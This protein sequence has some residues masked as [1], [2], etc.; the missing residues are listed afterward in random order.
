MQYGICQL[1]I[2]PL[3]LL[4]DEA[5]EMTSQLLYGDHFKVLEQRKFWSKIR[6][7]FDNYEGWVSN[8]QI[9]LITEE[10]YKSIEEEG[11]KDIKLTSDLVSFASTDNNSLIPLVIGSLGLLFPLFLF[12]FSSFYYFVCYFFIFYEGSGSINIG[13]GFSSSSHSE[14]FTYSFFSF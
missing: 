3:R 10:E 13:K 2:V 4:A 7:A 1:S 6:I 9:T 11:K 5:S 8:N 14:P 12:F